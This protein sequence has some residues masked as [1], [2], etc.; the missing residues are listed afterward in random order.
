[1]HWVA[2]DSDFLCETLSTTVKG[3]EFTANL[4]Q[5]Y[6]TILSE[7]DQQVSW[8]DG[9]FF[10]SFKCQLLFHPTIVFLFNLLKLQKCVL[11]VSFVILDPSD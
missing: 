2:H 5:I 1:M 9:Y 4:Y 7:N 11:Y 8:R 10:L 6:E 3:D